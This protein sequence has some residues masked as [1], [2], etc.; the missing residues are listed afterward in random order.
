MSAGRGKAQKTM[1]LIDAAA[2]ILEEIQPASVRA[3]CYRLFV[4]K[5]IPSMEK[6]NTSRVSRELVWA[7]ENGILPWEHVVDE[8]RRAEHISTWR[9]PKAMFAACVDQYRRDYWTDQSE[10]IE[11]WSEKGTVRGTLAPV[12]DEYG[13]TF[14]VMHGYGSATALHDIAEMAQAAD[15]TLTVLY[16]GDRDPSG[17][18][19]SEIDL[20][21]RLERYGASGC[22]IEIVRI[23]ITDV[24][25]LDA[26]AVPSFPAADKTADQRHRWYIENYGTR[27]WELDALSPAILR[28]RVDYEIN[29]RLDIDAWNHSIYIEE[30]ERESLTTYLNG[31]RGISRPVPKCDG[32]QGNAP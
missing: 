17:M 7:R 2:R 22:D 21:D 14:R 29:E 26:N 30:A 5:L 6:A 20:P 10:W 15:K 11:V 3:V 27:C 32:D 9:D 25:T 24:D 1:A 13:I 31:Y 23:A 18:H 16:V 28:Q 8:T 4:E 19:M 12:L